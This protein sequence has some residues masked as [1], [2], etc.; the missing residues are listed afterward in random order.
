MLALET[1][2]AFMARKLHESD[3]KLFRPA[4]QPVFRWEMVALKDAPVD[5]E[6]RSFHKTLTCVNHPRARW[7]TKNP[8]DRSIFVDKGQNGGE[9]MFDTEC[10]CPFSDLRMVVT[11]EMKDNV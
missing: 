4:G 11:K 10:S 7:S 9:P 3:P 8:W 2:G 6:D 1:R 5:W